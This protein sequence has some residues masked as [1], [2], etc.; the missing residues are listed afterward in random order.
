MGKL[1]FYFDMNSCSG[2]RTCQIACKDR[3]D[4]PIGMLYRHVRT[5]ETGKYPDAKM[6]HISSTCNH[7]DD[8]ACVA[9]CPTGAMYKS[10]DGTVLH[11][12]DACIGCGSC[13]M[14]CPYGVPQR[15]EA[16]R[17]VGKCDACKSLRDNGGNPACVDACLMR[18]LH[19]G[20]L[21]ELS[22]K[23]GQDAVKELPALPSSDLTHPN[24]LISP[25]KAALATDFTEQ[26]I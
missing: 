4:L 14:A 6:Y 7:C 8:A 3:N 21:D 5:Y 22:R 20:D 13:I 11:N 19:F 12:D 9:N 15:N 25:K 23:Y 2:C 24:M 17:I 10:E 1:G 26:P 16:T 18:C